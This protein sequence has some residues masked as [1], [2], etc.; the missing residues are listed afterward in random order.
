MVLSYGDN[1]FVAESD[2][3]SIFPMISRQHHLYNY[4]IHPKTDFRASNSW[5]PPLAFLVFQ[6]LE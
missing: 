1:N 3:F 5:F 6:G 4:M 2:G